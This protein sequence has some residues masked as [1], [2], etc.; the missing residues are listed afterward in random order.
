MG[1]TR[2][3][4]P[5]QCAPDFSFVSRTVLRHSLHFLET[6]MNKITLAAALLALAT[7][8]SAQLNNKA[9][10]GGAF[11][12]SNVDVD[13]AG[14]ASCDNNDKGFKL[15]AGYKL[16]PQIAIEG[17]YIDFGKSNISVGSRGV[18]SI[19]VDGFLLNAAGR[20]PFTREL[21]GVGRLGLAFVDTKASGWPYGNRTDGSTNAYFG[22]GLEYSFSKNLRGTASADFTSGEVAGDD[23]SVRLLSIGVQYDF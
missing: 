22:L 14:V 19:A 2:P 17:G 23:G 5:L 1:P 3:A 8:A 20:L 10:I 12:L 21:T 9:Y 7:S 15:Y 4:Q 13:C 6:S 18:G 16:H 11:G